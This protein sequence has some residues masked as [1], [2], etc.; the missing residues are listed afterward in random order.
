MAFWALSTCCRVV[1]GFPST[2]PSPQ[3]WSQSCHPPACVDTR[4]CHNP[5]AVLGLVEPREVH[6]DPLLQLVQVPLWMTP[7]A[8]GISTAPLSLVSSADWYSISLSV[9]LLKILN[10]TVLL[11]I[12]EGHHLSPRCKPSSHWPLS[13]GYDYPANSLS[14]K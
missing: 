12:P 10:G 9:S 3:A 4:Y 7:Y 6:M 1:S 2:G 13:S 11:W 8:S 5:G 14:P